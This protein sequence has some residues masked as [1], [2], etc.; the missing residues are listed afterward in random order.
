MSKLK[1]K[2]YEALLEPMQL[3]LAT[4]ARWVQLTGQ[5]VLSTYA[6][7]PSLGWLVFV[8]LP[9]SEAYAPIYASIG[10]STFLLVVLLVGAVLVSLFLSRRMTG[11]IQ[12]LTQGARRIG[13]GDLGCRVC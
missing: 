4:M 5:R 9:L 10:R 12:L 6:T 3:E 13:S 7:V 1:R 2:A 8:E 11:P